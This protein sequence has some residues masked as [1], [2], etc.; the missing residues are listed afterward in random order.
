VR[1]G[2]ARC[3]ITG[4]LAG[5]AL[6]FAVAGCR[7]AP[8][9][10][11]SV[12]GLK[13]EY[14]LD[15]ERHGL[16]LPFLRG[17]L[18]HGA[19][20]QGVIGVWP[21]VT[22]PSHTTLVTGVAPAEHGILNNPEFDPLH[23][24][25]E[26]WYWYA[27]QI[28]T[29]TL[30]QAA[31]A[32]HR[33][34]ASVGWPVTVGADIDYL[35]PEYWRIMGRAEELAPSDR[36]LIAALARPAGLIE[37]LTPAAGPYM[38]AN[39]TSLGGDAIKAR[40]ATEILR[41]HHPAFMTVHLSSLD[42]AQHSYGPFSDEANADLEA[43]DPLLAGL[44][45]A[46]RQANPATVVVVVSDHGFVPVPQRLNLAV[47]FVEA[48][49]VVLADGPAG[50]PPRVRDWKAQPWFAG[51]MAAIM[52]KDPADRETA[53]Q[54]G[55]LLRALAQ[56][57]SN[58]IAGVYD[59][60]QM[61]ERGGFP[62]AAFVVDFLPGYYA[63]SNLSGPLVTPM[64]RGHGGHGFSPELADM[65][66]AFFAIGPTIGAGRDLG[67]ID[68]RQIAPTVAA[69]LGVRLPDSQAATLSLKAAARQ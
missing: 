24:L 34:T 2:G 11:I 22:Y 20:A 47:P 21:T 66:S 29:T 10:M 40:Y 39:D 3:L 26:P 56:D 61:R 49:L 6:L 5:L 68:M 13:P 41:R 54:V 17:M 32:A 16:K 15:A 19:Y 1:A 33:V 18:A 50:Q 4:C 8:V 35:I 53:D 7:A 14:V 30:W 42:D 63:G 59:A 38:M 9:L 67:V 36:L 58:G 62:G 43:L 46:A 65:R 60:A 12:D 57:P 51:G 52:L 45:A 44:A 55:G 28:R 31:R 23:R 69:L 37:S 48:G 25:Q 64:P 27:S